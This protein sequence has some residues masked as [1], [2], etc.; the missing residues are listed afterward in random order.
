MKLPDVRTALIALASDIDA[1]GLHPEARKLRELA[2]QTRRRSPVR[3]A[4]W[5]ARTLTP[6]LIDQIRAAAREHPDWSFGR[7]AA[8]C[9][10]NQGRVSEVLAGVRD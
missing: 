7:I 2:E 1:K 10:V 5:R 6:E 3:K 9:D 8:L 4:P